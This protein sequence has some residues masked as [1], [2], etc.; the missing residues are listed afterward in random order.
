[1][2]FVLNSYSYDLTRT[3][4]YHM[5]P[6][7]GLDEVAT[8]LP[9]RKHV[10]VHPQPNDVT[11]KHDVIKLSTK[12]TVTDR[13][14]ASSDVE[15]AV[16]YAFNV[17]E[18]TSFEMTENASSSNSDGTTAK[19]EK[20]SAS[21][22]EA[23]VTDIFEDAKEEPTKTSIGKN[24]SSTENSKDSGATSTDSSNDTTS[25]KGKKPANVIYGIRTEPEWKYVWNAHLLSGVTT[26]LHSDW[27][28]YITHGFIGQSNMHVFGK[29]LYLTLIA[30]RSN[31]F[32]GEYVLFGL[33]FKNHINHMFDKKND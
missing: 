24:D 2:H 23:D 26:T 18:G 4:Q 27:L 15:D 9:E 16:D 1:M 10:T 31:Q 20:L 13:Q 5:T 32:A 12:P 11:S 30:R 14:R 3:L 33:M 19:T 29:S 28:L 8:S 6:C 17:A 7:A 25:A 21:K 22:S